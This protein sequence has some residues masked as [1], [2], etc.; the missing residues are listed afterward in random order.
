[1]QVG[2]NSG[3]LALLC[4][5]YMRLGSGVN[6]WVM[7]H[8]IS[9]NLGEIA[10]CTR[11]APGTLSKSGVFYAKKNKRQMGV[12]KRKPVPGTLGNAPLN[13]HR[14]ATAAVSPL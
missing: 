10:K 14:R 7:F 6:G 5:S 4:V 12:M 2:W 8:E 3:R 1:M 13:E 11:N 9:R